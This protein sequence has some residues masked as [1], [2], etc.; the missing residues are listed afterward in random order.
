MG[1]ILSGDILSIT[2]AARPKCGNKTILLHKNDS[3]IDFSLS[4][5]LLYAI[6]LLHPYPW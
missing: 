2:K 5:I 4:N 1:D 3:F 6:Y